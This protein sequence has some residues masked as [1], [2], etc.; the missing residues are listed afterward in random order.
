MG[1]SRFTGIKWWY[2]LATAILLAAHLLGGVAW[3][4]HAAVALGA[5]QLVH[6]ALREGRL[7]A[8]PVQVRVAYLMLLVIG[9]VPLLGFIH[10]IQLFGTWA[11]VLVGYCPLARMLSLLPWNRCEPLSGE[12]IGRT[13]FS[14]PVSGSILVA[15]EQRPRGILLP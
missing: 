15:L 2:W 12:L 9:S 14:P 7:V 8:F 13:F 6:F 3:A 4:I 1:Q 11:M 5:I 10:W